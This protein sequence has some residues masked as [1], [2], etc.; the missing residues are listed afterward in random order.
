MNSTTSIVSLPEDCVSAILSRTS[1]QDACRFSMVSKTFVSVA[2]SDLVWKNFL[3]SDYKDILSRAVNQFTLKFIS[4]CKQLYRFLCRPVLLDAGNKSFK[5]EKCSGKKCYMM[6]ATELSIAWSIDPMFWTWKS[7]PESRFSVVAELRTVNWL[8]IEGRMRTNVLTP[9]TSY[10]AY[11]VMK[12]SHHRAYGLDFAPSEVTIKKGKIVKRGKAYL[13]DKD[14]NKCNMEALFY[15]N[16][17]NRMVQENGE[18][19]RMPCKRE[20]GWMEIEIG[21]FCSGEGDE[22]IEMSVAEVGH[23]LKGGLV[24]EGIEVRPKHT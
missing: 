4:S 14:E 19:V 6:S 8:E 11:L 22:E 15:G 2:N 5:L 24:L 18:N 23:Q 21:E 12:V 13:C 7:I 17:R 1:P 10:G 3:P 9:N 16:R 20:D